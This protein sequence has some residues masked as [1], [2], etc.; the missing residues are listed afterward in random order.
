MVGAGTSAAEPDA[1]KGMSRD[2]SNKSLATIAQERGL[3][4]GPNMTRQVRDALMTSSP[5]DRVN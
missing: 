1:V 3:H 4:L 5:V 2:P